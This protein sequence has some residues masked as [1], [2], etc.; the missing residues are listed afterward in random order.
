MT[1]I[2]YNFAAQIITNDT[3]FIDELCREFYS[4][5]MIVLVSILEFQGNF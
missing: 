1:F 3:Q 2:G 4:L 5:Q